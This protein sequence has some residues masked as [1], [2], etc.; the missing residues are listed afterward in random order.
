MKNFKLQIKNAKTQKQLRNVISVLCTFDGHQ[1]HNLHIKLKSVFNMVDIKTLS[2][3]K[4]KMIKSLTN[5]QK[6]FFDSDLIKKLE[7]ATI[8]TLTAEQ[9]NAQIIQRKVENW[10]E[11]FI[12]ITDHHNRKKIIAKIFDNDKKGLRI[13]KILLSKNESNKFF[14]IV[15]MNSSRG[16]DWMISIDENKG[17]FIVATIDNHECMLLCEKLVDAKNQR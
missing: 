16:H 1:A 10:N 9:M 11:F 3:M 2:Q 4:S 7:F 12:Q 15:R 17:R 8:Q 6:T 5:F 14:D 13:G